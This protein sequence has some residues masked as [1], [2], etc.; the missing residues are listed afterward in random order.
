MSVTRTSSFLAAA[1]IAGAIVISACASARTGT[2]EVARAKSAPCSLRD[3]DSIYVVGGPLY[4]DCSVDRPARII[5]AGVNPEFRVAG[6][7]RSCYSA[8]V[9]FVV[10]ANGNPEPGTVRLLNANDD[11]FADAMRVMVTHLRYSPGIKDG[12][13]VRQIVTEHRTAAVRTEVAQAS[14]SGSAS[15][16]SS[17]GS[18]TGSTAGTPPGSSSAGASAAV[19]AAATSLGSKSAYPVVWGIS[20]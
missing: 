11:Q 1:T 19:A 15:S 13:G 16:G 3:E 17:P 5:T 18:T 20:C 8:T 9:E 2:P 12:A 10:G 14:L 6:V 7:P 4:R